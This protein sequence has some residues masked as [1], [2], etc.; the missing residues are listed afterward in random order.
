MKFAKR[1]LAMLMSTA[2]MLTSILTTAS[3]GVYSVGAEEPD[4]FVL[5]DAAGT[6]AIYVDSDATGKTDL[7]QVVRAVGDLKNDIKAVTGR[8]AEIVTNSTPG[9]KA[10][11]IGTLGHSDLVDSLAASGKLDVSA[12]TGEWE[13]FTIQMIDS[14][15]A[16]VDKAIVIAGSDARGTIYGIYDLSEAI[17]VSPW[18]WWGDV[19]IETTDTLVLNKSDIEKT[20]K[21]DVQY[22]G[23]FLNDEE[24]FTEWAKQFSDNTTSPGSPNANTYAK[25]FELMLRLKANVLW[26]AMHQQSTAFNAYVNP[27]TG[28]SYNAEMAD[29]YGIVM[30]ASHCEMLLRNSETEWVPWCE[31]NSAKYNMEKVNNDWKA[32]Y[33]YTVN[34]AAM[35]AYWEERVA[36]NYKLDNIYTIGLRAVHDAA[37]NCKN[38]TN[39]TTER[40]AGVVKQAVEA[41]IEILRKYEQKYF[42]E[43]GEKKIFPKVFCPYKEAADYF[44]YDIG[45]PEETIILWA[46]DNHGYVRAVS[47]EEQLNNYGGAGVY[48]HVSYYDSDHPQSYLWVTSTPLVMIYDEMNKAYNAG[49]D[50]CWI[51]NVGDLKPSEIATEF[52][53]DMGWDHDRYNDTNIN[54]FTDMI[55]ERNFGLSAEDSKEVSDIIAQ[56]YQ[57]SIA[58]RPEYQGAKMGTEYSLI[59]YGD[60]AQIRINQM[61]DLC[62]RSDA[63]YDKLPEKYK[64]AYYQ[65]VHYMI[66]AARYSMEKSVYQ[67]KNQ[68]YLNQGRYASVNAYAEAS[69][70]AYNQVLADL[71]YYNKELSGGKWDKIINPYCN[72]QGLPKI[73]ADP[74]P[75]TWLSESEASEGVGSV[76]EGQSVGGEDITLKFN[77]ITND[78]RFI[79][80]FGK[81][82]EEYDYKITADDFIIFTDS[83]GNVIDSTTN[84]GKK[85]I[86]GKV[87][88]EERLW[89]SIDWSRITDETQAQ[90]TVTDNYGL[91]KTYNLKLSK[92]SVDPAAQTLLGNKGHYETNGEVS[93]EAEHFT[94]NVA[95]NGQE[96]R[97]VEGRGRS[98]DTMKCFPDQSSTAVRI[99]GNYETTSPYLEYKI[100]FETPGTY[101]GYFY[102]IPTL[103]EGTGKTCRT[104]ISF[105]DGSVELLRGLSV[106]ESSGVW[107]SCVRN[108]IE[109]MSIPNT[110]T[111]AAP[112]WYSIKIYKADAGIEFD[113]IVL[114]KA[115]QGETASHL[116]APES[117]NTNSEY[118]APMVSTLREFDFADI[119]F[120]TTEKKYFYDFSA[121]STRVA[122]GYIGIDNKIQ[123]VAGKGYEWSADTFAN[124]KAITR[125][126][127]SKTSVRDQGFVYGSSG[128][129]LRLS[130][131]AA[132]TYLVGIAIGDR[133]SGGGIAVNHMNINAN[134]TNVLS[135]I[136]VPTGQ[137][138][139]R[140][141]LAEVGAD[142]ILELELS[143]SNWAMTSL[144]ISK[145]S[146]APVVGEDGAFVPDSNGEITIETEVASEQSEFAN[147]TVSAD[148]S[149]WSETFG[150]SG[151]AM[152]AGPNKDSSFAD[153]NPATYSG[154]KLN[155]QVKFPSAGSYSVWGYIKSGNDNDDSLHV[156]LD[157]STPITKNDTKDTKGEFVWFKIGTINV[158]SAGTHTVSIWEREDGITVDKIMLKTTDTSPLATGGTMHREISN[159][160]K[161]KLEAAITNAKTYYDGDYTAE[162]LDALKTAVESGEAVMARGNASQAEIDTATANIEAA[163]G[164]L[165]QKPAILKGDMNND[166]S[167]NVA[168]VVALRMIIMNGRS[169]KDEL[170][171]GDLDSDGKLSVSDVVALR[172]LIM[173]D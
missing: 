169:T 152:Y 80:V 20:E 8:D 58:K 139:E 89:A 147:S 92:A 107:S 130:M 98:G 15:V 133:Q 119:P 134:G 21:P 31:A 125:T 70:D 51:L 36:A 121:D 7:K 56:Y 65:I 76:C 111:V 166:G 37:I 103:N 87:L 81:G 97:V 173:K 26:P 47:T 156:S 123:A 146:P 164:G 18:Y 105:N 102:R 168:D 33:D 93:I 143:G 106:V 59:N 140:C 43:T 54:E 142:G 85:V 95:V 1:L 110:M 108:Q 45:L 170:E 44:K 9:A 50:D 165:V 46:D 128:A 19:P 131:N 29:K 122:D 163:I 79:D 154:P 115:A 11:I 48:Y 69:M 22:R 55:S 14:P 167:L 162:S 35:N 126:G 66:R 99:E 116:G 32:S 104:G 91:D 145:Y 34:P 67:Q 24:N 148:G 151:K 77:S 129:T 155:Y 53:L 6:A 141:F 84:G 120:P 149:S 96:W 136:S 171:R 5:S 42:E 88:I 117:Y 153:T 114:Y 132:G 135:E 3:V 144:E 57:I 52:F 73:P 78:K 23:I 12:V 159:T 157:N 4:Q 2:L 60:E 28:I 74:K 38:L 30:G 49:S 16:G 127:Q 101:K 68:L 41:Q 124:V 100:Y 13:A 71:N 72:I 25:V 39:P 94:N 63:I 113:K 17:G 109:K 83:A 150:A 86:T 82:T 137:T 62:R 64:A 118:T 160:D 61:A 161:A 112:G 10:I 172:Q 90:I 158:S 27:A 75:L 40:K 138:I